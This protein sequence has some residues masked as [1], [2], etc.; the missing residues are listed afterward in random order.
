MTCYIELQRAAVFRYEN[1]IDTIEDEV[2]R[3]A[4]E[5]KT[6]Y[7]QTAPFELTRLFVDVLGSRFPG[8]EVDGTSRTE[9]YIRW[10]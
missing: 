10:D 3:A 9:F 8:C 7:I 5:G 4:E 6:L 2:R 1:Y